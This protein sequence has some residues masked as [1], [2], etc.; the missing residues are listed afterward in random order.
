MLFLPISYEANASILDELKSDIKRQQPK[1]VTSGS[2]SGINGLTSTAGAKQE[3][4][5]GGWI[6]VRI[7]GPTSKTTW[8]GTV[9]KIAV[10]GLVFAPMTYDMKVGNNCVMKFTPNSVTG[11][12]ARGADGR[13]KSLYIYR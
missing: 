8:S 13:V 12:Y 7:A 2:L 5:V 11:C 3:E 6:S 9:L 10:N 1:Q 4:P